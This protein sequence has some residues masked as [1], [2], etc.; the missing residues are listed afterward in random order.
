MYCPTMRIVTGLLICLLALTGCG[1]DDRKTPTA[2]ATEQEQALKFGACMRENGVP[3]FPDPTVDENGGIDLTIPDGTDP[4]TV[5]KAMEACRRYQP[6]GGEP[7]KLDPQRLDQLRAYA[8]CMR[9]NGIEDFPD[10]TDEGIQVDGNRSG[11]DPTSD[12]YKAADRV[13]AHHAPP[14]AGEGPGL[15][16]RG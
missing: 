12:S 5:E 1:D 15:S 8:R 10:P 14:P 6:N 16:T 9:D 3:D 13:C 11:L 2:T 7:A 4:A